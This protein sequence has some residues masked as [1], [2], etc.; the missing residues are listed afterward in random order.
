[1]TRSS[2]SL[3]GR[4][5]DAIILLRL[6]DVKDGVPRKLAAGFGLWGVGKISRFKRI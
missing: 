1:M 5:V 3:N 6:L 4:V 2:V